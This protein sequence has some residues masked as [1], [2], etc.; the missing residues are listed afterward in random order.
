MMNERILC[1]GF[2]GQ[3][4]M[5]MGQILAYAGMLENRH[6]SWIPSYGPEMRGGTAYC[7]VV[8]SDRAIGSPIVIND[9]GCALIMNSP[10]LVKFERSVIPG[11]ILLINSTLTKNPPTRRD[12]HLYQIPAGDLARECG[13]SKAANIVMLGA[14]LAVT[15]SVSRKSIIAA[16]AKVFDKMDRRVNRLNIRALERG[17]DA[18]S[19]MHHTLIA[20]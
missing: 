14:Y 1:A 20:A 2:G 11:G 3:G 7:C 6:V 8:I 18:V 9:A 12:I 5:S 13:N 16:F 15:E 4:V 19:G 10:S 17:I